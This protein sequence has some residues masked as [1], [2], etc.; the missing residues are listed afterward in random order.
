M[1]WNDLSA[2]FLKSHTNSYIFMTIPEKYKIIVLNYY[3]T[4]KTT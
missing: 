1:S 4:I 3:W 2:S